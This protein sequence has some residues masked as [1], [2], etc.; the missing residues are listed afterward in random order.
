[1]HYKQVEWHER[2]WRIGACCGAKINIDGTTWIVVKRSIGVDTTCCGG[3]SETTKCIQQFIESGEGHPAIAWPTIDGEEFSG[4]PT[5]GFARF[6][7]DT[8][9]SDQ[10]RMAIAR[11]QS[12][13]LRGNLTIE[14]AMTT[15]PFILFPVII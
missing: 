11:G 4:R 9:L 10:I 15:I 14:D 6:I 2:A 7:K 3:E 12:D 5:T 1:M 8:G 13:E